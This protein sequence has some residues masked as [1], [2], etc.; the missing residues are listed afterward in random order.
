MNTIPAHI[1]EKVFNTHIYPHLRVAQCG[2]VSKIPL[3]K[4]D[5]MYPIPMIDL[6]LKGLHEASIYAIRC[7][8]L[9]MCTGLFQTNIFI[10][11]LWVFFHVIIIF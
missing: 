6:L 4:V 9:Y 11:L 10:C 7:R 5:E 2:Y 3:F 1:M 8:H